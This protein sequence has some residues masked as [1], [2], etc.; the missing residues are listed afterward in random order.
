M[1]DK[2]DHYTLSTPKMADGTT[3]YYFSRSDDEIAARVFPFHVHGGLE[4]YIL[5]EGDV[6]FAVESSLYK[7]S[8]GDAIITRPNEIHNCIL[9]SDSVH[10]HICFWFDTSNDFLFGDFLAHSFGKNNLIVPD[11]PSKA[12]LLEIYDALYEASEKKDVYAQ[13][14]LILEMLAIFR[15]FVSSE[16]VS[17][18]MPPLLKDILN[19]IERNFSTIRSL[20]YFTEKYYISSSTLNRLFKRYL[21]TTPKM[22]IES[23]RLSYSRLLLD[24]GKSVLAACMESGFPDYSNYIRLFKKR[25]DITPKQYKASKDRGRN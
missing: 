13:H 21:R 11:R 6:S 19:D 12:R 4:I 24:S 20:D 10:R 15:R 3:K 16:V 2:S 9:N 22:Y 25:F 18:E 7:M 5:L 1:A 17:G 14:Y 23:K 8:N